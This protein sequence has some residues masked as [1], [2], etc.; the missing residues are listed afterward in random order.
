MSLGLS[1]VVGTRTLVLDRFPVAEELDGRVAAH[2]ELLGELSLFRR[3]HL[4][5]LDLGAFILEFLGSG[6]VLGRQSFAVSAPR[7]I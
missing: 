1:E 7:R 3:V 5:E 2:F 6:G 4:G